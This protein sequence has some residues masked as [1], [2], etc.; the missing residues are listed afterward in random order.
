MSHVRTALALSIALMAS[1]GT[2]ALPPAEAARL[3]AFGDPLPPGAI[4]RIGTARLRVRGPAGALYSADGKLLVTIDQDRFL[5]FWDAD[6]K[7]VRRFR[8]PHESPQPLALSPDAKFLLLKSSGQSFFLWDVEGGKELWKLGKGL[9]VS[10][11]DFLPDGKSLVLAG[12]GPTGGGED[13]PEVVV[14]ETA[15]GK[16]IRRFKGGAQPVCL[17]PDGKLLASGTDRRSRQDVAVWEVATGKQFHNFKGDRDNW[18]VGALAFSPDGE[19]LAAGWAVPSRE[20]RTVVRRWDIRTGK[21]VGE[22]IR[23]WERDLRFVAFYPDARELLT[24]T[25]NGQC[26]IWDSTTGKER[27]LEM[28]PHGAGRSL[29]LSVDG[30]TLVTGNF[31][32]R[33]WDLATGKER[34]PER[35]RRHCLLALSPDGS[36]VATGDGEGSLRLW[37]GRT[38]KLRHTIREKLHTFAEPAF[39]PDGKVIAACLPDGSVRQW[40]VVSAK[41]IRTIVSNLGGTRLLYSDDSRSIR[42]LAWPKKIL[43]WDA[44]T[45]KLQR[46]TEWNRPYGFLSWDDHVLACDGRVVGIALYPSLRLSGDDDPPGSHGIFLWDTASGK[47]LRSMHEPESR[48]RPGLRDLA[49][50]D[51]ARFAAALGGGAVHVWNAATGRWLWQSPEETGRI[52]RVALSPDGSLLATAGEDGSVRLWDVATGSEVQRFPGHR[53]PAWKVVFSADGRVLATGG[54]DGNVFLWDVT[55]QWLRPEKAAAED[56][57]ALWKDLGGDAAKAYRA[58]CRLLTSADAPAFLL[59]RLLAARPVPDEKR[60]AHLIADLDSASFATRKAAIRELGQLGRQAEGALR[61]AVKGDSTLELKRRA[62]E[63]LARLEEE[64]PSAETIRIWRAVAALERMGEP[65]VRRILEELAKGPEYD[66]SAVLARAALRRLARHAAA[67]R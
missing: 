8:L 26:S 1:P 11:A 10:S 47:L 24:V 6:G 13:A 43:V 66:E 19:L 36:T 33:L 15:T 41:E 12:F 60:I 9:S 54:R 17:S 37:D 23:W 31:V 46:T 55:G 25:E 38:S 62:E 35:S 44:A 67:T 2:Q 58:Q 52:E 14:R 3:D 16:E 32:L 65:A 4:A 57:P 22:A 21:E 45:G 59:K 53:G 42:G 50:S 28:G 7:E 39:S 64:A 63:L 27:P 29:A 18:G 20:Y 51:D 5:S 34:Y 30:K 49:L 48:Y 61:A 40:E 56:L